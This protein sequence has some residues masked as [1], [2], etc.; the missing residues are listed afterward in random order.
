MH[1][2]QRYMLLACMTGDV[3]A[4]ALVLPL[5]AGPCFKHVHNDFGHPKI[6][7]QGIALG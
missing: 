2:S 4:H 6:Q 1:V 7:R 5:S 3:S